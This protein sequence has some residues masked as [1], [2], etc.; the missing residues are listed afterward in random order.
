[1][2]RP[3]KRYGQTTAWIGVG[4]GNLARWLPILV[5]TPDKSANSTAGATSADF[6]SWISTSLVLR[7]SSTATGSVLTSLWLLCADAVYE[8][9]AADVDND[10][11]ELT[12]LSVVAALL[13][14][15]SDVIDR[16]LLGI[17]PLATELTDAKCEPSSEADALESV[18]LKEPPDNV[19]LSS[20]SSSST[21]SPDTKASNSAASGVVHHN[22]VLDVHGERRV[23]V[24]GRATRPFDRSLAVAAVSTRPNAHHQVHW[25]LRIALGRVVG[26]CSNGLAVN[27]P[28][29]RLGRPVDSVV[30]VVG[31]WVVHLVISAS[32]V[33]SCVSFGEVVCLHLVAVSA[34]P[35][36][37][38]LVQVVRLQVER[39]DHACSVGRLEQHLDLTEHDVEVG[40]ERRVVEPLGE[41]ELETFVGV[42]DLIWSRVDREMVALGLEVLHHGAGESWIGG[43]A[44]GLERIACG[45]CER[46]AAGGCGRR[47]AGNQTA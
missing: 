40:S 27:V 12:V 43:T 31:S 9:E 44:C 25:A 28:G 10:E 14:C 8:D 15:V 41:R 20:S 39:R 7:N 5:S 22:Q 33:S 18:R 38:D 45:S 46:D 11:A 30:V 2:S 34:K 32:I 16:L 23:V 36:E 3:F 17:D 26:E 24:V 19:V 4:L 37:V 13:A 42:E 21:E 47:Q 35:F 29:E 6:G 1:M